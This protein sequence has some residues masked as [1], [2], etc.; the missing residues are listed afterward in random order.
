MCA[1]NRPQMQSLCMRCSASERAQAL[2][3]LHANPCA[4][5][6]WGKRV[7]GVKKE[8]SQ[9]A[10]GE[11]VSY[12]IP[13]LTLE[14]TSQG[15]SRG[16]ISQQARAEREHVG[17][18]RVNRRGQTGIEHTSYA[19]GLPHAPRWLHACCA[20]HSVDTSGPL[21]GAEA[22]EVRILRKAHLTLG[23]G[24]ALCHG[25]SLKP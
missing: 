24:R 22:F 18:D 14:N 7:N 21:P 8:R 20:P 11:N 10:A 15:M 19:R 25:C 4:H 1:S 2:A 12:V 6:R 17:C 23:Q 13:C 5:V 16:R 3:H 9:Q